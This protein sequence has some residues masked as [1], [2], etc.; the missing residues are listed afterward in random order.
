MRKVD[1]VLTAMQ[2]RLNVGKEKFNKFGG[3][4]YRS[5]EDIYHAV[6][7]LLKELGATLHVQ[8]EMVVVGDRFYVKATAIFRVDDEAIEASAFAR[9]P[10]AKKGMD[11]S[12]VTGS[13]SSYARKYAVAGLFLLDAETDSDEMENAE[14]AP[15]RLITD[16]Q[17]AK[18]VQ[19]GVADLSKIAVYY[20]KS[21]IDEVTEEEAQKAIAMKEGR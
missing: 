16:E 3:F 20:R 14:E 15:S 6:K 8:D 13:C 19:L 5:A 2:V 7:P 4:A 9:E 21:S 10:L 17:K 1:E 18:L 12:Q 11:E